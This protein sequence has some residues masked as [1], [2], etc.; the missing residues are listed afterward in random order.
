MKRSLIAGL[1]LVFVSCLFFALASAVPA[2]EKQEN[3]RKIIVFRPDFPGKADQI[4]LARDSGAAPIKSL[5][6]INGLAAHL[7]PQ[8]EQA[9][10]AKGEVLRIDDDLVVTATAAGGQKGKPSP[11]PQPAQVLPWG[12]DRI[13]AELAWPTATGLAVNVAILD[14]GIDLDHVDLLANIKGAVNTINPLKT[15]NDD[16]GHGTHVAGIVAAVNNE[17]GVVGVGPEINLYA[18][19][20]LA[21]NGS[22]WLSDV[23][24]GLDWCINNDMQVANMSLGSSGDNQSFHDAIIRAYEAGVILVAAAGNNGSR[25]GSVDYP[26]KYPET[27]AVSAIDQYGGFASFSSFGPEVDLAAPGVSIF[28][29]YKTGYYK[30]LSGTSM[31]APHV[32][33]TAAL[34]L[35]MPVGAYDSDGDGVWDPAEVQAKLEATAENLGLS[36]DQQGAGLVR[37]DVAVQ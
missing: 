16:N 33:G 24:E 26:A 1:K 12:V 28:S 23:I 10:L 25:G 36:A 22:G 35:T 27:I 7:P 20:V 8:A 3:P 15:A 2:A 37:A 11:P 19:K 29:A 18:V 14:T 32:A 34:V 9:L 13:N 21:K 6:L 5:P 31:A 17:I 4:K 30:T